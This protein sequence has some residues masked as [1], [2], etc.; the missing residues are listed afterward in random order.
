[1]AKKIAF[2]NGPRALVVAALVFAAPAHG[3]TTLLSENFNTATS[4]GCNGLIT[5]EYSMWNPG[6][7]NRVLDDKWEMTSG[8]LFTTGFTGR[9]GVPDSVVPNRCSTNGTNSNV[10]RVRTRSQF[11][12]AA[13]WDRE[14]IY[15]KINGYSAGVNPW[16]GV[17]L[18]PRYQSEFY[19]YFAYVDRKDGK[20]LIT[21]KC[22]DAA[23]GGSDFKS[24]G[25]TPHNGNHVNGGYV[26]S[27]PAGLGG[28]NNESNIALDGSTIPVPAIGSWL[29]LRTETK[30]LAGGKVQL[31]I[32]RTV[33]GS[34]RELK[35]AED[36]GTECA[37]IPATT[38]TPARFGFRADNTDASFEDFA[39]VSMP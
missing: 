11:G 25:V 23:H 2:R 28:Q 4:P 18:W 13:G 26:Y 34:L 8:S 20:A 35:R 19:L 24:D 16:D 12:R 39:L 32:F 6:D 17:A 14:T 36:Q 15:A 29:M 5:N 9:T 10:F 21:K 22:A 30:N 27:L 31:R 38:T 7:P 37:I 33:S 1:M 3:A